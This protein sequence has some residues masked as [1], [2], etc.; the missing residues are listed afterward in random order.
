M[1]ASGITPKRLVIIL[2]AVVVAGAAQF[3]LRDAG[4]STIP[5]IVIALVPGVGSSPASRTN[6]RFQQALAATAWATGQVL[7]AYAC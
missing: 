6:S 7:R 1:A 5:A 4:V 3:A 2:M